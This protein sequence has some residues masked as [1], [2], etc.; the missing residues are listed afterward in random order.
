[1]SS[2][3]YKDLVLKE[4]NYNSYLRIPRLLTL[5]KQISDPP[6]HDEM[7]FIIIHQAAELWFKE[8]LHETATL[9][10]SLHDGIVSRALKTLKRIQAIMQLQIQQIRL[11][12]TL[13]PVEF[14]GFRDLLRPA[15]GFQSGQFRE[16][17]FTYGLRNPFFL[18]FFEKMPEIAD[19]LR[20]IQHERSVYD[21]F[22]YCL[23]KS[24]HA[25]PTEI[26]ERDLTQPW[27]LNQNL[28]RIIKN[29]YERP[30]QYHWVLFFE[31][32]LDLDE[33]FILWRKT[34]A[35]MVHRTIGNRMGTGGSAGYNFLKSREDLKCFPE[36]W[37]VRN[38]IGGQY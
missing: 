34:H 9:I 32:M 16:M 22:L 36:L 23:N 4:L 35:V 6:H 5:Q 2:V 1:M 26:L 8:L 25:V 31:A 10:D 29:V 28:V 17:E 11:L 27:E 37:E 20:A 14:A 33:N 15:S 3:D 19:R 13:T 18:K 30:R 12:S 38:L 24:G 7:F 21:E